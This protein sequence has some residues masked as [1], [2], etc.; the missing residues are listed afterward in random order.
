MTESLSGG[1]TRA[2]YLTPLPWPREITVAC[3]SKVN[4]LRGLGVEWT[5][6]L[7]PLAA[8]VKVVRDHRDVSREPLSLPELIEY[9]GTHDTYI[10]NQ[11]P[12]LR[13]NGVL[14]Y[15]IMQKA[16]KGSTDIIVSEGAVRLGHADAVTGSHHSHAMTPDGHL[17]VTAGLYRAILEDFAPEPGN[18][19]SLD[20]ADISVFNPAPSKLAAHTMDML[21]LRPE[22]GIGFIGEAQEVYAAIGRLGLVAQPIAPNA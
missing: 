11:T 15:C 5:Q 2:Q 21:G 12:E 1:V 3:T 22:E 4:E 17:L 7:A 19:A 10:A 14:G 16:P 9:V 18:P 6:M 20:Q 8:Q 13:L